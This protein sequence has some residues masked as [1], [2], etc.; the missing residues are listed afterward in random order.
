MQAA[1]RVSTGNL[2]GITLYSPKE[3]IISARA[4]TPLPEIET[5]LAANGQHLIAEPP[6]LTAL[7]GGTASQ[8]AGD[9]LV[10]Q[11]VAALAQFYADFASAQ[12]LVGV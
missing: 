10:E 5:A 11:T 8:A 12:L 3:L 7:L 6:D 9:A 4:G 2:T 1:R